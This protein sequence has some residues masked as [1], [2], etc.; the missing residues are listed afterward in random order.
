MS[1]ENR[2]VLPNGAVGSLCMGPA[3]DGQIAT[4]LFRACLDA[5]H[6]VG[7]EPAFLEELQTA[8]EEIPVPQIGEHGGI[9]EWLNDYEA[10]DPGHRHI[11]QLFALYPGEQIDPDRSPELAEAAYKTWNGGLRMAAATRAGAAPGSS[12][13]TPGCSAAR[14]RTSIS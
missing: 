2:F 5:G 8:L 6:L 10:A 14:K 13:I 1:P 4:A 12:I 7:D 9:M 11:S 3:M